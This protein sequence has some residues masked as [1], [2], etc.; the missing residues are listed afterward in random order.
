MRLAETAHICL[1]LSS[2]MSFEL[3]QYEIGIWYLIFMHLSFIAIILHLAESVKKAKRWS[4]NDINWRNIFKWTKS[5]VNDNEPFFDTPKKCWSHYFCGIKCLCCVPHRLLSMRKKKWNLITLTVSETYSGWMFWDSL[6]KKLLLFIQ[7]TADRAQAIKLWEK[8]ITTLNNRIRVIM[9]HF[10]GES[11]VFMVKQS[12]ESNITVNT[13]L[14]IFHPLNDRPQFWLNWLNWL[15]DWY[16]LLSIYS[17]Y[18]VR[19]WTQWDI[20]SL[21]CLI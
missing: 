13:V 6:Q 20:W 11:L 4:K 18:C 10:K 8:K 15:N 14:K 12:I 16:I 2:Q 7:I 3:L 19:W 9:K 1:R 21:A 17:S 5:F